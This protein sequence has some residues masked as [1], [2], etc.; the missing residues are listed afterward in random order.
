MKTAD[1]F[2][3][4]KDHALGK[5]RSF[6]A[7]RVIDG[8]HCQVLVR[9]Y[10]RNGMPGGSE[11]VAISFSPDITLWHDDNLRQINSDVVDAIQGFNIR[12]N[13]DI[14]D[15]H[16]DNLL[17]SGIIEVD[18]VNAK[19]LIEIGDTPWLFEHEETQTDEYWNWLYNIGTKIGVR[20]ASIAD[21]LIN[22]KPEPNTI[23]ALGWTMEKMP[24]N[25]VP[26]GITPEDRATLSKPPNPMD[27]GFEVEH[28]KRETTYTRES[29]G[30]ELLFLRSNNAGS[31]NGKRYVA[32]CNTWNEALSRYG[33]MRPGRYEDITCYDGDMI[34]IGGP[35]GTLYLKGENRNMYDSTTKV[36]LAGWHKLLSRSNKIRLRG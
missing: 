20:C 19:M 11:L 18:E 27:Y 34:L 13:S 14:L 9:S 28:C 35:S 3:L 30:P 32:A 26:D 6:G 2:N 22:A 12:I 15:K 7:Y 1:F 29:V 31:A 10:R 33:G 21:A 25:Y 17:D 24:D 23:S 4:F 8:N 36:H 5:K 16:A